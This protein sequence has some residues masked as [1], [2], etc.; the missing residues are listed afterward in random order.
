MI[1]TIRLFPT[2]QASGYP[3]MHDL[4]QKKLEKQHEVNKALELAKQKQVQLQDIGFEIYCKKVTQERIRM[5]IFTN[6]KLD[7]YA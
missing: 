5:E 1:E 7:V 3:D 6:R 4:A 2:V